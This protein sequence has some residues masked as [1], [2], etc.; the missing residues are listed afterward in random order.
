MQK[1]FRG[2]KMLNL[3][4]N[5]CIVWNIENGWSAD[6]V[7]VAY[8]SKFW[9][10]YFPRDQVNTTASNGQLYKLFEMTILGYPNISSYAAGI[11]LVTGWDW[12]RFPTAMRIALLL[13]R[14]LFALCLPFIVEKVY[15]TEI[16]STLVGRSSELSR[17]SQ[18]IA[19]I[20][21]V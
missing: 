9:I 4:W 3:E 16:G 8:A 18:S 12:K 13:F 2:Y 11:G 14:L 17:V 19:L 5:R 21:I 1:L 7:F 6:N 20:L 10:S 15:N